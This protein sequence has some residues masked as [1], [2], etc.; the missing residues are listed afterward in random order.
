MS[1]ILI[2]FFFVLNLIFA[3]ET[4]AQKLVAFFKDQIKSSYDDGNIAII[5]P[6][7]TWH[8]RFTYDDEHIQ[9]YNEKPYGAGIAKWISEENELYGIYGIVFS[10]SNWHTQTMLGYIHL[11]H[12]NNNAVKFG[13][14]Y[15]VGLTQR[16][17]YYYIP[18]PLPLPAMGINFKNFSLQAAYVPGGKNDGNVL[19]SWISWI[20]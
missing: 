3:D 9:R 11:Y 19:F 5:L 17:E 12:L 18:L 14:G 6:I 8:N 20:F 7:N 15:T 13:L 16:H 1:K 2:C 10:D 4:N